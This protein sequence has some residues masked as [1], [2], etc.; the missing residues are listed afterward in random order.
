MSSGMA[1]SGGGPGGGAE[2]LRVPATFL[3]VM[4]ILWGS[5]MF[6]MTILAALGIVEGQ[7]VE[8]TAGGGS[9]VVNILVSLVFLGYYLALAAGAYSMPRGGSKN[10]AWATAILGTIP[11]C[12]P[13]VCLGMIPGIWCIVLLSKPEVSQSLR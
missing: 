8:V 6:V 3:M 9:S 10:V 11:C 12:S 1:P 7:G 4:A 5:G 13:W 2:V